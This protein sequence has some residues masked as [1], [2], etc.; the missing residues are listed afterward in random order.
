MFLP[1]VIPLSSAGRPD[2]VNMRPGW[3]IRLMAVSKNQLDSLLLIRSH[4]LLFEHI[5]HEKAACFIMSTIQ[6]RGCGCWISG[7]LLSSTVWEDVLLPN[8]R[9]SQG[10]LTQMCQRHF[11]SRNWD[12]HSRKL[13][14]LTNDIMTSLFPLSVAVR[15]GSERTCTKAV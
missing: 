9:G 12:F 5:V 11:H 13:P 2:A 6:I 14:C 8:R 7:C 3:D 15:C 4:Q 1:R 10:A